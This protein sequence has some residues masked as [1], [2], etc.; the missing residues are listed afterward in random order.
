MG[1]KRRV[2]IN[3]QNHKNRKVIACRLIGLLWQT[4]IYNQ[5]IKK[6][7]RRIKVACYQNIKFSK[8]RFD[9]IC[10]RSYACCISHINLMKQYKVAAVA[11]ELQDRDEALNQLKLQLL[12][13]QQ[14]MK[15]YADLKRKNVQ[16]EVGDWVFLKLR[17]HRQQSVVRR[18]NQKLAA[19]LVLIR[20]HW[21]TWA[22]VCCVLVCHCLYYL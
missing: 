13:A 20:T 2:K 14:Q 4:F 6:K 19:L 17:P 12:K 3:I 22:C 7:E 8:F 1:T 18:I 15:Y 10:Q 16:F 21:G 11:L 5:T 9:K